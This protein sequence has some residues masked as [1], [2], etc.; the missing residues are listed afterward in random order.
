MLPPSLP[1]LSPLPVRGH[2]LLVLLFLGLAT[3]FGVPAA[4]GLLRPHTDFTGLPVIAALFVT[5]SL[6]LLFFTWLVVLRP[7]GLRLADLGLRPTYR[8]WYPLAVA[9]GL[10]CLPLVGLVNLAVE[11]FIGAPLENPQIRA[12]APEGF[13]WSALVIMLG[14]VGVLV[15]FIEEL[16][17]RGLILGW[18][19]KHLRL[20]FAAPISAFLFSLAHG[21]P[22][23]MPALFA[24]GLVLAFIALRS[25]SLW[26]AVIV[27][28]TFNS[29]MTLSVYIALATGVGF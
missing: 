7:H 16:I 29:L 23:L 19:C 25:G 12:I 28:G 27:H 24:M 4:I 6:L 21:L 20:V 5:Q 8:T 15:P 10:L 13:S 2:N 22:Q 14:L 3:F 1:P 18:L 9:T 17:F 26:P 11:S